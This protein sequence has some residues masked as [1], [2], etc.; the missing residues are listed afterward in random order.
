MKRVY[1]IAH[2]E[3]LHQIQG[4]GGGW[5]DTSLT[6][7][8]KEQAKTI[9]ERLY[10]ALGVTGIPIYCSDLK[11]ASEVAIIL[12]EVF[13]GQV[14]S[15]HRLREMCFGE[16]EG[17]DK[18]WQL[19]NFTPPTGNNRMDHRV[20]KHAETRRELASRITDFMN[21]VETRMGETSII[22]THGFAL[23]FVILSWLRIPIEHMDYANFRSHPGG[24]TLLVE[25]DIFRNREVSYVNNI[26]FMK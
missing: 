15:D 4:L 20:Y 1:V 8:G 21:N 16:A 3:S 19:A 6:T 13:Q 24:V 14:F 22:V 9:A 7:R 25:D 18:N 10:A 5:F 11:R 23:T 12:E 26:D 2:T 17:K